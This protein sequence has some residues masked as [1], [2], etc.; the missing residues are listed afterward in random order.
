MDM[1]PVIK[2]AIKVRY[3][4]GTY[5][6]GLMRNTEYHEKP[7]KLLF[8]ISRYKFVAKM[9]EGKDFVAELG[10]GGVGFAQTL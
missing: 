5:K 8:A 6:L 10:G 1:D 4:K 2:R 7:Q 3:E 9:L